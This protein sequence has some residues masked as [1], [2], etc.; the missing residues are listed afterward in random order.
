MADQRTEDREGLHELMTLLLRHTVVLVR[1]G[2]INEGE[3][4]RGSGFV[5]PW[6]GGL[7]VITARHVIERGDW[8]V[9]AGDASRGTEAPP[10]TEDAL[11]TVPPS[12]RRTLLIRLRPD[13]A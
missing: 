5:V 10:L 3:A 4:R 6:K 13:Q 2:E 7:R 11:W 1:M 9:E 12:K 8:A